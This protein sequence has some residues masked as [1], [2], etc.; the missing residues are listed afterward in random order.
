MYVHNV[1]TYTSV[2][3]TKEEQTMVT[4]IA[5]SQLYQLWFNCQ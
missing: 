5:V 2:K 4:L 1:F 3:S